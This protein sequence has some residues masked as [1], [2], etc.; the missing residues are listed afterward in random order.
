MST[1]QRRK[2]VREKFRLQDDSGA[3]LMILALIVA[4]IG[5]FVIL[6]AID[7]VMV[8]VASTELR[9]KT[10]VICRQV[11][12]NPVIQRTAAE[13]FRG[14]VDHMSERGLPR[15]STITDAALIL[16]TM[17]ENGYFSMPSGN[18]SGGGSNTSIPNNGNFAPDAEPS[19]NQPY[20]DS[21][22]LSNL[23][24][25]GCSTPGDC[26]FVGDVKPSNINSHYPV[27]VWN[28]TRDSGNGAVS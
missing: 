27:T 21:T 20:I 28:N 5:G 10:E 26:V 19:P 13:V 17:P 15:Y 12:R 23:L 3:V 16:P 14:E 7:S 11:A 1:L 25:A 2:Y 4:G 6:L 24:P 9:E 8:K 22:T 18:S